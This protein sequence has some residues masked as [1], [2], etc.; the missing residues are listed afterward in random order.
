MRDEDRLNIVMTRTLL[1]TM[2]DAAGV[3]SLRWRALPAG[4]YCFNFHRVGNDDHAEFHPNLFSC[5][6]ARFAELLGFL[7]ENFDVIGVDRLIEMVDS[8]EAPTRRHALITFDDGYADNYRIAYPLLREFGCPAGFFLPTEFVG[9]RDAPWWDRIA[10][11]VSNMREGGPLRVPG[12]DAPVNVRGDD[13]E[14]SIRRVLR[15]VKDNPDVPM[16]DKVDAIE[17]Q[18]PCPRLGGGDRP[19]FMS[20]DEVREMSRGGMWFGSHTRSHRIL[21]HLSGDEQ[22]VE[23]GE[24]KRILEAELGVPVLSVAYPVGGLQHYTA[25][26]RQIVE[27]CGYR[28]AFNYVSGVNRRPAGHRFDLHRIE[29]SGN[30]SANTLRRLVIRAAHG[31]EIGNRAMPVA[32]VLSSGINGLG[33]VRGLAEHGIPVAVIGE[34]R[35]DIALES[36]YPLAK[37]SLARNRTPEGIAEL[38]RLI[39]SL[40]FDRAVLIPTSDWFVTALQAGPALRPGFVAVAPERALAELLVDKALETGRVGPIVPVPPT[41]TALPGT[42]DEL[43]AGLRLPI[44]VKP[45]SFEH[46][47]IGA[48]NVVLRSREDAVRFYEQFPDVGARVVAQEVIEGPD[49]NLWVCH[50]VFDAQARMASAFTFRRLRLSPSH[51][52]VTSYAVSERNDEVIALVE[53][54]GRELKYSGPAMIEFKWDPRDGV[55]RYIELNPRLGLANYLDSCAGA[56]TVYVSYCLAAGLTLPTLADQRDGVVFVSFYEDVYA[57][58]HDG[59]TL[60]TIARHYAAHFFRRHVFAYWSIRDPLP[61]LVMIGR[62]GVGIVSAA[63]RKV[64][65]RVT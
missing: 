24:S 29:V 45:R 54:L 15:A 51:Y 2:L 35:H 53:R 46:M 9:S 21:S 49:E 57:R 1:G 56:G 55:Y 33:A 5:T 50:A 3:T 42:V 36:R 20:W 40:P 26:T 7:R 25:E 62:Q 19:L 16:Q 63:W 59:E 31:Q 48:K 27:A 38:H 61:G 39:D 58:R 13:L 28:V 18:V 10:W 32:V 65:K 43:L 52:G 47:C 11:C 44:I 37:Y 64:V 23:L 12:L 8:G 30:P 14:G 6:G 60:S 4:V 41:L 17:A 22:R 34:T